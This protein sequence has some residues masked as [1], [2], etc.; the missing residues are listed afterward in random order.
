[1]KDRHRKPDGHRIERAEFGRSGRERERRERGSCRGG[2]SWV[3]RK[4]RDQPPSVSYVDQ[5]SARTTHV[6]THL[7]AGNPI[8]SHRLLCRVHSYMVS[9]QR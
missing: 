4:R 5:Q 9:H 7:D 3:G 8:C 6:L 2:W 1:M